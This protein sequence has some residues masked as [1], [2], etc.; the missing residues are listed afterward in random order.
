MKI[1]VALQMLV[2]MFAFASFA[3][4]A[5]APAGAWWDSAYLYRQRIE[6]AAGAAALATN[7][8]V[9]FSFNHASYVAFGQSLA[10]GDDVRVVYWNGSS[11]IELDRIADP[12]DTWNLATTRVWFRTQAGIAATVTDDNY[13]VYYGNPAAGTPPQ[14]SANVFLFYDDF[15][16][17]TFDAT[18]W[19]T[20]SG[21]PLVA[22]GLLTLNV[23]TRIRSINA[24]GIDTIWESNVQMPDP[25]PGGS[26]A[27]FHFWM[28]NSNTGTNANQFLSQGNH[29]GFT[30][31]TSDHL[32][33]TRNTANSTA[34]IAA[35]TPTSM[36]TY[37]FTRIGTTQA[38]YFINGA[39]VASINTNIP[40]GTLPIQ[41]FDDANGSRAQIYDWMRV[42]R[43]RNPEPIV[44][45][46]VEGAVHFVIAHDGYGIHCAAEPI[47]VNV[48]DAANNP[49]PGY[50]Q[51][52][53]LNTG[54]GRGDW[55]VQTGGG[56]LNNGTPNDGIATYVWSGVDTS[57]TFALSYGEGAAAINIDVFQ[58][59]DATI[60]DDNT[61]GLLTWTASG[62][63]VTSSPLSNPPPGVIP[64]FASPQVA[65]ANFPIYLTA[66]GTTPTDSTC[67]VIETYTGA[68]NLKFW[69]TYVNPNT[70]TRNVTI[71]GP[72]IAT[73]EAAA[74][75]QA[76]T[77]TNGQASVT[78]NYADAGLINIQMKDDTTGNP[79]LPT[80]IRGGTG[81]TVVR[82]ASFV[83]SNIQ[84]TSD[85]FANPSAA[86][87]NGTVF[88]RAGQPFTATVTAVDAN[89]AATPNFGREST[90]ESVSFASNLIL[91][92]GG[93]NPTVSGPTGFAAFTNG[94]ATGTDFSWPEVG[95]ITLTPQIRDG[96]YLGAGNVTGTTTGNVGRFIPND[97]GFA[98]NVSVWETACA[99]GAFTYVGQ[100]F[101]YATAPVLTLTARA[102][103][104]GTTLNYTGAF[105]KLTNGSL[106]S[107]TYAAGAVTLDTSG[108][109]STATDPAILDLTGGVATLTFNAGGGLAVDRSSPVPPFDI[110]LTLSINV[111]DTDG[112]A[113]SN[114]V[115]HAP[116]GG[117]A[118][119]AGSQQR[120]G[121][122]A[123]RNA[124]GSELLNLPL[125]MRAEYFI[126]PTAGFGVNGADTCTTG[127]SLALSGYGGNLSAGETCII[128]NG[129]PGLSGAGC[130]APGPIGQRY[131]MPPLAGD[132]VT[133]LQAPGSGNDGT[134]TVTTVVP[135]W[136][137][138]D[139]NTAVP[140]Q[141]NPSGIATF[142][143]Y[144]GDAKRIF[145]TEK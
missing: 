144:Q 11:W 34:V 141:E 33:A 82:P 71:N 54:S 128:D 89:G 114:P 134:V 78:A 7:Y 64:A 130:A 8:S 27:V 66:Y 107:R 104:G 56:T 138:F 93:N 116:P 49:S 106:T 119:S 91:P 121:R 52:I 38:T 99:A 126:S 63:T 79:G 2:V 109:P 125:P 145:Q 113:A 61:E 14:N 100:P 22:A 32:A 20:V 36:Q 4:Y 67:G 29:V 143:V 10:T 57:A 87:A 28:A 120:Y 41:V 48:R 40:T 5:A 59:S 108:L 15:S 131:A 110:A 31:N 95:I 1:R 60:R 86:A 80:G 83:V 43:Y 85:S 44:T 136:L 24:F 123:F 124:V 88:I 19:T 50:G 84:R 75:A 6:I 101:V 140:G 42:R 115:T 12:V 37:A 53:T 77:F 139:W 76:I 98:W 92:L 47:V 17:A 96:D 51:E 112:V 122:I 118:F 39:Q 23:G 55:S 58:S 21:T 137:R 105:F 3:S 65:A 30:A 132:F 133:I 74:V 102:V 97:F 45:L 72:G 25:L 129:S 81:N 94:V 18:K 26:T 62:F 70:G 46:V 13:Y 73:S 103:G 35:G 111:A 9:S 68:K 69:S 127:V 135:A 117:M 90:P 16:A 142:G